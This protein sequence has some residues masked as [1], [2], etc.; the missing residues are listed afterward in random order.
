MPDLASQSKRKRSDQKAAKLRTRNRRLDLFH[1]PYRQHIASLTCCSQALEDLSSSFPALL[2]ALTTNYGTPRNRAKTVRLVNEGAPL[3]K[4]AD[5]LGLPWWLRK[6]PAEALIEPFTELPD[7]AE[8]NRQIINLIP[9]TDTEARYW[10]RR[11]IY[12]YRACDEDYALWMARHKRFPFRDRAR[13][14]HVLL[15]AWAWFSKNR[16]T[17]GHKLL[18]KSWTENISMIRAYDEARAWE[19]RLRLAAALGEGLR[20][21]WFEG[22]TVHGYEFVALRTVEDFLNE[23]RVMGNCLDQYGDQV[24]RENIR[25]FSLRKSGKH[26]ADVE[27]GYHE[28]DPAIPMIEQLR[29]PKNKRAAPKLWQAAYAWL[30]SQTIRPIVEGVQGGDRIGQEVIA[31]VWRPYLNSL[32]DPEQR[33][34]VGNFAFSKPQDPVM[35]PA[36][37]LLQTID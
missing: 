27:I 1:E 19:R 21:T 25:V 23:S 30:G 16:E 33:E 11:V 15:A 3:K 31:S 6:I 29:G 22:G 20:D 17:S 12:A 13:E 7:S 2:F 18:R 35:D 24:T 5:S 34:I 28:D 36:N 32:R 4:V 37:A 26:L 8:F 9:N 10:L 14:P